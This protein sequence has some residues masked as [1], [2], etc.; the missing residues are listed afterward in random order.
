MASASFMGMVAGPVWWILVGPLV[1]MGCEACTTCV[2]GRGP[3]TKVAI[4]AA[5]LHLSVWAWG[6]VS[7]ALAYCRLAQLVE[8][9]KVLITTRGS[10]VQDQGHETYTRDVVLSAPRRLTPALSPGFAPR[11]TLPPV[12][13]SCCYSSCC[14]CRLR[15]RTLLMLLVL[16]WCS[17]TVTGSAC[18]WHPL[19]G[20]LAVIGCWPSG[21]SVF[22]LP[23]CPACLLAACSP[24]VFYWCGDL[25]ASNQ[26]SPPSSLDLTISHVEPPYKLVHVVAADAASCPC[27]W[28]LGLSRNTRSTW[29]TLY[30]ESYTPST[31]IFF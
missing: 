28:L 29:L 5:A 3:L 7:S 30:N 13:S 4:T 14:C 24:P 25:T 9:V 18:C 27:T 20:W 10:V 21:A 8:V 16:V 23:G 31:L 17:C 15:R 26:L 6:C 12:C 19:A 22:R 2:S 11:A 1:R